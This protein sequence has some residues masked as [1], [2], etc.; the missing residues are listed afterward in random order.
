[1]KG[2]FSIDTF[3]KEQA[4]YQEHKRHKKNIIKILKYIQPYP[5]LTIYYRM[6]WIDIGIAVELCKSGVGKWW[7]MRHHQNSNGRP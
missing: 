5:S 2:P 7:V 3:H 4:A 6:C 1:M